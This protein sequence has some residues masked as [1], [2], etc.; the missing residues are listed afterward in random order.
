MSNGSKMS[1][2]KFGSIHSNNTIGDMFKSVG[3]GKDNDKSSLLSGNRPR[4]KAS[5]AS[6]GSANH[7]P[8]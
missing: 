2:N 1:Q 4:S 3:G 6:D 8:L 7:V 5:D